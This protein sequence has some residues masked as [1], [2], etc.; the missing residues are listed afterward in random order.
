MPKRT[1]K[2]AAP[3]AKPTTMANA[4]AVGETECLT[5]EKPTGVTQTTETEQSWKSFELSI[6]QDGTDLELL[7]LTEDE[8]A[9]L[10]GCL[11]AM[12]GE[13]GIHVRQVVSGISKIRYRADAVAAAVAATMRM[14]GCTSPAEEFIVQILKSYATGELRPS[15]AEVRIAE[16]REN[17][18]LMISLCAN[19][20]RIEPVY[21]EALIER[22]PSAPEL[23]STDEARA[24]AAEDARRELA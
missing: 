15:E 14:S 9:T 19:F 2:S 24:A 22:M 16:F 17:W 21:R 20:L 23:Y 5:P 11:L 1:I 8:F 6:Y 4:E 12:R 10:K 3:A 13:Q 7:D 18:G